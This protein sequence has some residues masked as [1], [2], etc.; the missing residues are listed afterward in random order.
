[1]KI[2]KTG[3]EL[4][5]LDMR[6]SSYLGNNASGRLLWRRLA[7][8]ATAAELVALLRDAYRVDTDTAM[9]DAQAFLSQPTSRRHAAGASPS[10]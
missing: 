2:V 3:D 6:T 5:A 7:A 4:V 1:M 8:G 10:Q 9:R